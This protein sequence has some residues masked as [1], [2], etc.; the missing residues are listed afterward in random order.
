M[1]ALVENSTTT[2]SSSSSSA[3]TD[4]LVDDFKWVLTAHGMTEETE[5]VDTSLV[6]YLMEAA[7][8]VE[9]VNSEVRSLLLSF[10]P[11]LE[12]EEVILGQVTQLMTTQLHERQQRDA[13]RRTHI[14]RPSPP[15]PATTDSQ[16]SGSSTAPDAL[17]DVDDAVDRDRLQDLAALVPDLPM[18]LVRHVYFVLAAG[19]AA[20]AGTYLLDNGTSEEGVAKLR[21]AKEAHDRKTEQAAAQEAAEARRLRASL[22]KKFDGKFVDATHGSNSSSSSSGGGGS[23]KAK[24]RPAPPLPPTIVAGAA[25][26]RIRYLGSQVVS[27]KGEKVLIMKN[28]ADDYDG[29]S[30]GIIKTKGKRGPG[31]IRG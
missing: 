28:P 29:G 21:A 25:T 2:S 6:A 24:D 23:G 10:F 9:D 1:S 20:E 7:A 27:T 17:A 22:L 19:H 11:T 31:F 30:R 26:G 16:P 14:V 5:I 4:A 3:S 12:N 8:A 13:S 18:A 15:A